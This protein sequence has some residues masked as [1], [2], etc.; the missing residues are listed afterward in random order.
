[1]NTKTKTKTN[2]F[3]SRDQYL[4]FRKDWAE[5]AQRSMDPNG[6]TALTAAHM[7]YFNIMMG[8][9]AER[10]FSNVKSLTKIKNGHYPNYAA[11]TAAATLHS[12]SKSAEH[13][14][15]KVP[16]FASWSDQHAFNSLMSFI[17]ASNNAATVDDLIKIKDKIPTI[18]LRSA[19]DQGVRETV[20]E[21]LASFVNTL[22]KSQVSLDPEM[23]RILEENKWELY[24]S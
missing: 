4:K 19:G 1:M 17:V 7:M 18:K 24:V 23:A 8:R 2:L 15:G 3:K 21:E 10:G 6:S 16:P 11:Y 14:K 20:R 13:L 22:Y 9:P 5:A 12:L